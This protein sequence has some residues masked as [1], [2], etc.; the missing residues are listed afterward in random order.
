MNR[1]IRWKRKVAER[2]ELLRVEQRAL[3]EMREPFTEKLCGSLKPAIALVD[4]NRFEEA[5]ELVADFLERCPDHMAGHCLL[6]RI[7]GMLGEIEFSEHLFEYAKDRGMGS[8]EIF[9]AMVD[10]YSSCS[11]FE[12]ARRVIAEAEAYGIGCAKN[13]AHVMSGLY[14]DRRYADI[15]KVYLSLPIGYKANA[16]LNLKYADALRKMR[17]YDEAID[18]AAF[19]VGLRGTLA[20]KTKARI[21]MGYCEMCLGNSRKAYELLLEEYKKIS[22]LEDGG[23]ALNFFPRLICGMVFACSRGRIPQP[24]STAEQW[25]RILERIQREG[26]GN[27]EDVGA[28]LMRLR[29]IPAAPAQNDL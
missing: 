21:I 11:E 16:A 14:A 3:R 13:Y 28:A 17:R 8:R 29:Q 20:E 4:A 1:K 26:R 22:R 25:R 27:A 2:R 23:V 5:K 9:S 15:E 12:K 7:H 24:D 10:A 19:S 18:A 6:I